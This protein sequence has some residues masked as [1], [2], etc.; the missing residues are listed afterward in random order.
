MKKNYIYSASAVF[1]GIFAL[2]DFSHAKTVNPKFDDAYAK[3]QCR[4][5]THREEKG[6]YSLVYN[7]D[8]GMGILENI[9]LKDCVSEANRGFM[10][11]SSTI[12][13]GFK[14]FCETG[15]KS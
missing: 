9:S 10:K 7:Y 12:E 6:K 13:G 1:L 5:Q 4:S 3:C 11:G 15:P 14:S 2:S 8:M